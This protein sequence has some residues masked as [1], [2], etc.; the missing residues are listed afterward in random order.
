MEINASDGQSAHLVMD[1]ATGLPG[2]ASYQAPGVGGA[3]VEVAQTYSDWRDA[4]GFKMPYKGQT[5]QGGKK[6]A[7]ITVTDYKFNT[8]ITESEISKR[9]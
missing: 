2:K 1:L 5:E 4:F 9:P 6:V 8:G 7:D 3:Q